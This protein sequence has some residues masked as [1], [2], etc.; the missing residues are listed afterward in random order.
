MSRTVASK[1]KK[2]KALLE[3]SRIAK[4]IPETRKFSSEA[5]KEMLA[6]YGSVVAKPCSSAGGHGIVKITRKDYGYKM[7]YKGKKK[8]TGKFSKLLRALQRLQRKR[9]YILQR[10][11]EL[12]SID[13]RPVDYRVKLVQKG[14]KWK[15]TAVVAKLARKGYFVTNICQGGDL[16]KSSD[17]IRRSLNINPQRK[18]RKMVK[19]SRKSA[20]ILKK[21]FPGITQLGFDYGLDTS[22]EIW[23][24]EVNTSPQ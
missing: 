2:T 4:V 13:G 7:R 16:L 14:D 11:I 17:A 1:W 23:M 8:K 10:T 22:G 20:K 18:K 15:V 12:A 5:L 9:E 21:K 3:S 24:F 6:K 19:L